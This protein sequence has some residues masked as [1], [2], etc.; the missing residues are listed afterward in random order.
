VLHDFRLERG[1]IASCL[2]FVTGLAFD[3]WVL[4]DWL[5]NDLGE[6]N[7]VRQAVFSLTLMVL[8]SMGFF[9]SFFLSFFG[10]K[11]HAPSA[12]QSS[13]VQP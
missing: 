2:F 1:L 9:A 6:L 7:A 12:A 11:L 4:A 10:V 8:G 5:G 3:A 13:N